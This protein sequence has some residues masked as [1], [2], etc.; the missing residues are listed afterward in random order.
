[1]KHIEHFRYNEWIFLVQCFGFWDILDIM[2]FGDGKSSLAFPHASNSETKL[3]ELSS[4][5]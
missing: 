1:M 4:G 2:L 5:C 3:Q